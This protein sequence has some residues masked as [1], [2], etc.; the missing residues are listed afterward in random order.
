V[1]TG[2]P[3]KGTAD[4][5]RAVAAWLRLDLRR[6]TRSLTVVA[7]MLALGGA[8]VLAVTAGARRDGSA[9]LRLRAQ[10]LP[11]TAVVVPNIPG[12]D[13]HQI[14]ELPEVEEVAELPWNSTYAIAG[15]AVTDIGF[16]AASPETYSTVEQGAVLEGRRLD[17]GAVGEAV[18]GQ[19]FMRRY[20]L[21]VGDEV[22]ARMFTAAQLDAASKDLVVPPARAARGPSQPLRIVGVVRDPWTFEYNDA[23]LGITAS[24]AFFHRYRAF[25]FGPGDTPFVN[26]L[27]RLRG[28]QSDLPRFRSD[29][30]RVSGRN[31]IEVTDLA[32][33]SK[34][35]TNATAFERDSLRVVALVAAIASMLI[36]GQAI[37]RHTTAAVAD[38]DVLRAL[39]LTRRESVVAAMSGPVVVAL[40]AAAASVAGAY[41][42]SPLFPN[43]VAARIE[44][45]PG[46][47]ADWTVLLSGGGALV[48]FVALTAFVAALTSLT[49]RPAS[50][51]VRRSAVAELTRRL[52]LPV[53]VTIGTRLA[54][55]PGHGRAAVP[56]RPALTGA[57]AGVLGVVAAATFQVGL[58]DA[59]DNPERYGQTWQVGGLL[60]LNGH[61]FATPTMVASALRRLGHQ[62]DVA[63]VNDTRL[64][65]VTIGGRSVSLFSLSPIGGGVTPV[66]I[67]GREPRED[68]EIALAPLTAER[69]DVTPGQRV[70][71]SGER[72]LTLTVS[73]VA[74]VPAFSHS[75]YDD[76]A[77]VRTGTFRALYPS[78]FYKFHGF[79]V[80]FRP[81][82]DVPSV[83]AGI[84][85]GTG[86]TLDPALPPA[87]VVNLR[88]VRTLPGLVGAFLGL[89]ATGAVVHAL[90]TTVRRRRNDLAV[91][92]VLGLT[93][94]QVRAA[95]AWQAT[96]VAVVG[97][98]FGIP[99][100][101][102]LGR[103][104]WRS[105]AERTPVQYAPPL[106]LSVL[107][108]VI[109]VSVILANLL[110][111]YPGHRA[112]RG[113]TGDALRAE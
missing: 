62:P 71:V 84:A 72:T 93:A 105:V 65:P 14:R 45:D 9:M 10:S 108:L 27:V 6:R 98:L 110:A 34:R 86:L 23:D 7:L 1:T 97:L 26:A 89:L 81:G 51:Y 75:E 11:A 69:L 49:R 91:L 66:S 96:T 33:A 21:A 74:F 52:G 8:L 4:A 2:L 15:I 43:G 68:D 42:A 12:F 58:A 38:L 76:G 40:G 60:G 29:L 113:H 63:G 46:Y 5:V 57:V 77:W 24:N 20:H 54:L 56:V 79:V 17:N 88:H 53:T 90:L 109:P 61:D 85:A 3:R 30:A 78:G 37:S 99:L 44:P 41:L 31:D 59:V 39:G 32:E 28:G 100:G 106:A 19:S 36:I 87:D 16:P 48:A 35:I 82:T 95:V 13:W 101:V 102:I 107:L 103:S 94:R 22:T 55:E 83:V 25:L 47:H 80:R 67:R 111:L 50:Q 70:R 92:R 64:V 112:V 18:A 104:L 73:G